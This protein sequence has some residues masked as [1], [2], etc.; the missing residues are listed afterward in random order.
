MSSSEV[1]KQVLTR[2]EPS[3]SCGSSP[4]ASS[5]WL[6]S[7]LCR[8]LTVGF[9]VQAAQ[10]IGAG[11]DVSAFLPRAAAEISAREKTLGRGPVLPEA[12]ESAI[13]SR[14]RML[15]QAAYN[16]LPGASEG[17]G[18]SLYRAAHE[19]PTLDG[20]LAAAKSKRYTHT[21]LMR[22]LLCAYL[23]IS[24]VLLSASAPY[25]RVLAVN[26]RGQ[27]VLRQAK[28]MGELLLLHTGERA[29]A[30]EYAELERRAADLY[31][32]FSTADHFAVNRER[33]ARL[34]RAP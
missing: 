25:V 34:F 24:K 3:I 9:C 11:E 18:N 26:S 30:C 5:T 14:L 31:S 23:G 1:S 27:S 2:M 10:R 21:R 22:L 13:L 19:E 33:T 7:G 17:L 12:L 16:A 20:V 15:P 4:M 8:A 28:K 6:L 29:P 32:L